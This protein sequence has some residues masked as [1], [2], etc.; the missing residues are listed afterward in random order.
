MKVYWKLSSVGVGYLPLSCWSVLSQRP[1]SN[2]SYCHCSQLSSQVNK[3]TLLL[4][5]QH[6][7]W[8]WDMEKSGW[9][10]PES[11]LPASQLYDTRR[12]FVGF[13]ELGGLSTVSVSCE[14]HELQNDRHG[15]V[16]PMRETI[17]WMLWK[18]S[19]ASW[20]DLRPTRQE[21]YATCL[22]LQLCPTLHGWEI[23][24]SQ[25]RT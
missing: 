17:V 6:T 8:S 3:K 12:Y 5:T 25:E 22:V 18:E 4:L 24:S 13:W 7:H 19:T 20:L 2:K 23:H 21:T 11:F 1:Q 16:M 10:W 9:Y 15:K 14:Y